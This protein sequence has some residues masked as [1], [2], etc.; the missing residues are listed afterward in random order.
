MP[1][2]W[3]EMLYLVHFTFSP[4]HHNNSVCVCVGCIFACS[5]SVVCGFN[6][7][8]CL[9]FVVTQKSQIPLWSCY[10][11]SSDSFSVSKK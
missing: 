2:S 7:M 5:N 10:M 1:S 8:L 9:Y 6:E 4:K 11:T 3:G